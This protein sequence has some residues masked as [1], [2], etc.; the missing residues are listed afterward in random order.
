MQK[1]AKIRRTNADGTVT[2]AAVNPKQVRHVYGNPGGTYIAFDDTHDD[3]DPKVTPVGV[4]SPEPV[5]TVIK[6]LNR[7]YWIDLYLRFVGLLVTAATIAA[8]IKF[9]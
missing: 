8:A 3:S 9:S 5:E 6:R 2:D 4:L 1:L 7:P